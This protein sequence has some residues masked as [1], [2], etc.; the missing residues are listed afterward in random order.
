[1]G[2][3]F[4]LNT[5]YRHH[6]GGFA[7]GLMTGLCLLIASTAVHASDSS[8]ASCLRNRSSDAAHVAKV[9]DGDTLVL[10]NGQR[11]RIIGINTLELNARSQASRASA[12][13]ATDTLRSLVGN[14][15]I[16][17]I[18][19]PERHDRH[20]RRLAH[21]LNGDSVSVGAELIRRGHATAVAVAQ[22]TLCADH[23][24][25]LESEA[26]TKSL[27]IWETPSEWFIDGDTLGRDSRGF[28][29]MKTSITSIN[30]HGNQ[31]TVR[32]SNGIS[33][34][35]GKHWSVAPPG[36]ELVGKRVEIRGWVGGKHARPKL[37]L[38]HP[39]NMRILSD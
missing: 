21:V 12:R 4:V 7:T 8:L 34:T 9:T 36:N 11:V 19:G 14:R 3:L 27:G 18:A 33:A 15:E 30:S 5:I 1:M 28:K 32:F 39:L 17:L 35:L 13:T 31:S 24:F 38:H 20:G 37:T 29:V 6:N 26:R 25:T 16:T 10:T 2:A 23:H 22:N